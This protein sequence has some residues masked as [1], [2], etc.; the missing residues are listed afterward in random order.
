MGRNKEWRRPR[1]GLK[2][3]HDWFA[4]AIAGKY[5]PIRRGIVS[6]KPLIFKTGT[7]E[8]RKGSRKPSSLTANDRRAQLPVQATAIAPVAPTASMP[9]PKDRVIE[10]VIERERVVERETIVERKVIVVREVDRIIVEQRKIREQALSG[11]SKEERSYNDTGLRKR[12]QPGKARIAEE[13]ASAVSRS[14]FTDNSEHDGFIGERTLSEQ[15]N[16]GE[17]SQPGKGDSGSL[18]LQ[19]RSGDAILANR[20]DG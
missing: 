7:G 5:G 10:R 16:P 2:V 12:R 9:A 4:G 13:A 18:S 8:G 15:W 17:A 11:S 14:I 19:S 1:S 3:A 6:G 20:C